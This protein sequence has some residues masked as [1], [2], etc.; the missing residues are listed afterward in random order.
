MARQDPR[1]DE[2]A[3][4]FQW[5]QIDWL[6]LLWELSGD[7]VSSKSAVA[8]NGPEMPAVGLLQAAADEAAAADSAMPDAAQHEAPQNLDE[9]LAAILQFVGEAGAEHPQA[10][11]TDGQKAEIRALVQEALPGMFDILSAAVAQSFP[12]AAFHRE[13]MAPSL[14]AVLGGLEAT[15][16]PLPLA[17]STDT[18]G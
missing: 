6:Q 16:D 3:L 7:R 11:L 1:S 9:S 5:E 15:A 2:T 10:V 12:G 4:P 14:E 8:E 18:I 17:P 13:G